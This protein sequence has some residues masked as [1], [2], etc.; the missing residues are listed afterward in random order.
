MSKNRPQSAQDVRKHPQS[1]IS[2]LLQ[3]NLNI[4]GD[5]NEVSA[6]EAHNEG[7]KN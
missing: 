1:N 6:S 3:N 7:Y 5:F 4:N 2:A